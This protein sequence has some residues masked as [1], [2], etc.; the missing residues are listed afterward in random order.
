MLFKMVWKTTVKNNAGPIARF[1]RKVYFFLVIT[2]FVLIFLKMFVII[3]E[4]RDINAGISYFGLKLYQPTAS[5]NQASIKI[6]ES[7]RF[8]LDEGI[9]QTIL[10]YSDIFSSIGI[11][12]IW[13]FILKWIVMNPLIMDSSKVFTAYILS[14][15][16]LV[17]LQPLALASTGEDPRI[18]F[19]AMKNIY[20]AFW[21]IF[22]DFFYKF[23]Q[24]SGNI[25]MSDLTGIDN[26]SLFPGGV[27]GNIT[28][29]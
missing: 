8:S 2:F 11:I 6:I 14:I 17:L 21:I 16:L 19:D 22:Q 24:M 9:W 4:E 15:I 20:K 18:F 13:L 12:V 3:Y 5:L 26:I 23:D 29:T 25:N 10:N 27:D 7:G 28:D 1:G